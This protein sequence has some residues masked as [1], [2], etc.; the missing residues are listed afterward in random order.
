MITRQ[1][2]EELEA[3]FLQVPGKNDEYSGL[4]R[5]DIRQK[6][7]REAALLGNVWDTI[8]TESGSS[9]RALHYYC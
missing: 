3:S 5:K 2:R 1:T 9:K 7:A 4:L 8:K 6:G